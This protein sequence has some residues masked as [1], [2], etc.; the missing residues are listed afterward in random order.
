MST[1]VPPLPLLPHAQADIDYALAHGT[2]T[3]IPYQGDARILL[4]KSKRRDAPSP[5]AATAEPRVIAAAAAAADATELGLPPL[6]SPPS[7]VLLTSQHSRV[8]FMFTNLFLLAP[9]VMFSIFVAPFVWTQLSP[10]PIIVFAYCSLLVFAS[11]YKASMTDPGIQPRYTATLLESSASASSSAGVLHSPSMI[12]SMQPREVNTDPIDIAY[13]GRRPP[14][15]SPTETPSAPLYGKLGDRSAHLRT[16][17]HSQAD[18]EHNVPMNVIDGHGNA[19]AQGMTLAIPLSS[20]PSG[21]G[22]PET[23]TTPDAQQN[24]DPEYASLAKPAPL[25]LK[26]CVTCKIY[27]HP[28]TYH[29][30]NCNNCVMNHDHCCPWISN[31]VGQRNYLYF[32]SFLTQTSLTALLIISLS[33]YQIVRTTKMPV[34]IPAS[35]GSPAIVD[36]YMSFGEALASYPVAAVLIVYSFVLGMSV[37]GL[38]GY[39]WYLVSKNLSTREHIKLSARRYWR[40]P[41]SRNNIFANTAWSLLRPR[42]QSYLVALPHT[43]R[44]SR[45]ALS[46]D[47]VMV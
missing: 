9:I 13:N 40:N 27:R 1:L 43:F 11:L 39:H 38:A 35:D 15:T 3:V 36:H 30:G 46:Q 5:N 7:T 10:A 20:H 17:A 33:I 8:T 34:T 42:H 31:C 28:R 18:T 19:K 26:Y 6:R 23:P 47:E 12:P 2:P 24:L 16:T 32:V 4:S 22:K 45:P 25:E 21:A 44:P 41:F 29:C 37:I 14:S